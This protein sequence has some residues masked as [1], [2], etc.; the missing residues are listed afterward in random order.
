M[1]TNKSIAAAAIQYQSWNIYAWSKLLQ[2]L[3]IIAN[4]GIIF[5]SSALRKKATCNLEL[6]WKLVGRIIAGTEV[7]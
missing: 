4:W 5:K 6:K 1:S 3:A 7:V 2:G